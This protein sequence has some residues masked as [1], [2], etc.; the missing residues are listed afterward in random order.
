MNELKQLTDHHAFIATTDRK[1]LYTQIKN[2]V[3]QAQEVASKELNQRRNT[4]KL[5]LEYE[6]KIYEEEFANK[7]KSRIDE[8]IRE[9]KDILLKIKEEST[10]NELEF[11]KSKRIQQYMN[12]C[13]EIREAL[14]LKEM[15]NVKECQLEQMLDKERA[16]KKEQDLE[17]YWLQVQNIN[18]QIMDAHQQKEHC[19]KKSL[20]KHV[21]DTRKLQLEELKERRDKEL[22]EKLEEKRN[23]NALLEELRL[24]EF[25]RKMQGKSSKVTD[26][27]NELLKMM[28]EKEAAYKKEL[29][30]E[31]DL[32]RKM[33]SEIARIEAEETAAAKEKKKAFHKAIVEFIK[34][35][36]EMRQ[37]EE[38][39]QEM[40]DKRS[41]D[42]RRVDMCT[43]NNIF[44]ER[45]RKARVAE[46]CYAE[47][48]QQICEQYEKRLREEAEYRENK[49]LE[50]SFVHKEITREEIIMQKQRNRE[51]LDKQIEEL[52]R[53]RENEK[54]NFS[55][56]LKKASNDPEFCAELAKQYINEGIDYLEPH[57]NWRLLACSS[58]KYVPKP[59]ARS[60]EELLGQGAIPKKCIEP[61][62]CINKGTG[63]NVNDGR[64]DEEILKSV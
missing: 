35:V 30:E 9:R 8:D 44:L 41:E 4:L 57:A 10:K 49:M 25:D 64:G 17:K 21:A 59:P 11:L 52:K 14:R 26:Y 43:K 47:L 51:E 19:L 53:L 34:F 55:N 15:Q 58:N 6:D 48:K 42:L 32:H 39:H 22:Q 31:A 61:C 24:E 40:L 13:Y 54:D 56:D 63:K 29:Q 50:N 46:K 23:L 7:V 1:S 33:I 38:Q 18:L 62:G 3:H 28:K 20:V 60:L 37:L 16:I 45:Q 5:L 36:K 12:S 27:R 2:L